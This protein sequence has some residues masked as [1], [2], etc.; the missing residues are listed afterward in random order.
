MNETNTNDLVITGI[1]AEGE[2]LSVNSHLDYQ[3]TNTMWYE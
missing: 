3:T 1:P 2:H